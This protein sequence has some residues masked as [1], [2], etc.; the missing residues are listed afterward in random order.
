[1][2]KRVLTGLLI[3]GASF[4]FAGCAGEKMELEVKARMD[5]QPAAQAK[6]TVDGV[7]AGLT[8]ADGAFTKTLTKKPGAEVEVAVAKE[9]PGYRIK[10]W[11]T[12]FVMKLPKK[13]RRTNTPSRPICPPRG[14][15]PSLRWRRGCLLPTR[16]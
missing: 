14:I 4:L 5:G 7:E 6:V 9:M 15:S 1:M 12:T 2:I 13:E 16:W 8:G 11:R 10:P 3:A